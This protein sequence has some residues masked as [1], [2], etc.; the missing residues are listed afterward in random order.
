M[1]DHE[2]SETISVI[3]RKYGVPM[4]NLVENLA[5]AVTAQTVAAAEGTVSEVGTSNAEGKAAHRKM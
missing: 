3:A 4:Q 1:D 5:N 2:N